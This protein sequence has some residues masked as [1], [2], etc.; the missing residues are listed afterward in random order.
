MTNSI[1]RDWEN[2]SRAKK[3]PWKILEKVVNH[4]PIGKIGKGTVIIRS[5][6][7]SPGYGILLDMVEGSGKVFFGNN[8]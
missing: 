7:L 3:N 8:L 1:T 4:L 6:N 2:H 5:G